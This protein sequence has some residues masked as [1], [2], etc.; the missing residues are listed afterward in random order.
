VDVARGIGGQLRGQ[1]A[2]ERH[3][4]SGGVSAF[5]SNHAGVEARGVARGGDRLGIEHRLQPGSVGRGV[6]DA[7]G[8]EQAVERAAVAH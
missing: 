6:R 7:V 1:R 4:R 8:D 5:P 2:D 3:N